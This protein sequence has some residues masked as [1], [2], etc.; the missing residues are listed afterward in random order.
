MSIRSLRV[1]PLLVAVSVFG[2]SSPTEPRQLRVVAAANTVTIENPNGWPV[3][4]LLA[5]PGFLAVVDLALCGDPASN[6]PR[7]PPHGTV[8]VA[9]SDIVGYDAAETEATLMQWRLERQVD[10][11]YRARDF[12]TMSVGLR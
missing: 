2:C 4:Y 7:V 1:L 6:C 8:H 9:Y 11:T 10:G 12:Q 3:F 5:N